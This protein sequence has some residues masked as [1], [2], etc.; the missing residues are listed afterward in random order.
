MARNRKLK[1]TLPR[2]FAEAP[3]PRVQRSALDRSHGWKGTFNSG[4]LIPIFCDEMLPGDSVDATVNFFARLSPALKTPFMDNVHV[5][6]FFFSVPNRTLW[7]NWE[8]FN[9]AQ[10]K[11]GDSTD[12]L[13]PKIT[14]P[15]GGFAEGSI[16]DYLGLPTKVDGLVVNALPLRACVKI[17]NEWF[18]DQNLQD[19]LVENDGDGPDDPTSYTLQRKNKVRDY[20]TGALPFRQKGDPVQIPLG[21]S[22]PVSGIGIR[23]GTAPA[24][25]P[26]SVWE[27]GKAAATAYPYTWPGVVT[28]VDIYAPTSGAP[29]DAATGPQIV[30]DLSQS[31]AATVNAVR[32][33]F[34]FQHLTERDARGGTRY[35]EVLMQHFGVAPPDYRL[36]RP[37]WIGGGRS[38][39]LVNPIP[40]TSS[41]DQTTPQG[42][43]AAM[44]TVSAAHRFR[45]SFTEHCWVLGFACVYADLSYQYGLDRQWSRSTRLDYFWPDLAHLGEQAILSKE[46]FADGSPDDELVYGY[47][48]K[49]DHWRWKRSV[50]TGKF[51][52]NATGSLDIWHVAEKY[53]SRPALN[54][55]WIEEKPPIQRV[56]AVESE[57]EI[58]F[59]SQFQMRHVRPMPVYAMPG[60]TRM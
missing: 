8:K 15:A 43:L 32:E 38:P 17:W 21:T 6:T 27:T 16:Y 54:S 14:A 47:I 52:S 49:D 12:F 29:S 5:S 3:P 55:S 10:D 41:T 58:L 18:R 22:A 51:R 48:P 26:Q 46:L 53:G 57:P 34:A 44:G 28:G 36:Q 56:V 25:G 24:S 13:L 42:N 7:T 20:F 35:V 23:S 4:F 39:M 59:D 9:G 45:E 11:P 37:K 50:I 1:S 60:L 40:Q 30:A 19:S 33:S 31:V 2:N